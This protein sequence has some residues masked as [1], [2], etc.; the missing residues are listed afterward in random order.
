M[1]RSVRIALQACA[2]RRPR[3]PRRRGRRPAARARS[4]AVLRQPR[5]RGR[6]ALP[7]RPVRGVPQALERH[8]QRL[9][10]EDRRALRQ[11][12]PADDREE[13]ADPRLL[14]EPR[15][16]ADPVRQGQGRRR[17]LQRLGGRPFGRQRRRQRGA[18]V[19]QPDRRQG[20]ARVHLRAAEEVPRHDLRRP[21]RSRRRLARPLQGH[22]LDR[23]SA[24]SCARTPSGS[25]A[26]TSTSTASS[27]SRPASRTT[28]TRRS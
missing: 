9:R 21:Q 2:G 3:R 5:D 4:R 12:P 14:L 22:D 23:R 25:R 15:Q 1:T 6:P 10:Q 8:A 24:S 18:G 7:G 16:Q 26:G 17:E 19:A 11:G 20:R 27:G 13:A 28:A